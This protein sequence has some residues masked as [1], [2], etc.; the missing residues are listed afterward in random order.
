VDT[1]INDNKL[2]LV[3]QSLCAA[4]Q[5]ELSEYYRVVAMLEAQARAH[6]YLAEHLDQVALLKM[7]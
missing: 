2:G 3:A 5:E 6:S 1:G 4:M 7:A